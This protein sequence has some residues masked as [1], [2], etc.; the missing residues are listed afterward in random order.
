MGKILPAMLMGT[1]L[2]ANQS[3]GTAN[4][5]PSDAYRLFDAKRLSQ[6]YLSTDS[7]SV[8]VEYLQREGNPVLFI[9]GLQNLG[10]NEKY[11][12]LQPNDKR[13]K[14]R[15]DAAIDDDFMVRVCG[16]MFGDDLCDYFSHAG[17]GAASGT[18]I[19]VSDRIICDNIVNALGQAL[20]QLP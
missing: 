19:P 4:Y 14:E 17:R 10:S 6:V 12:G 7:A 11:R 2:S 18:D 8:H 15:F 13:L 16:D 3:G 5:K 9:K 20:E 1:F